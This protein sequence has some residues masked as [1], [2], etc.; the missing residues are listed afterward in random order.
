MNSPNVPVQGVSVAEPGPRAGQA[1][2]DWP[3]RRPGR[4]GG[5]AVAAALSHCLVCLHMPAVPS[6]GQVLKQITYLVFRGIVNCGAFKMIFHMA[7][8]F[9]DQEIPNDESKIILRWPLYTVDANGNEWLLV[10]ILMDPDNLWTVEPR[11][12]YSQ[13]GKHTQKTE[14]VIW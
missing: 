4:W 1:G 2:L 9:L 12:I 14:N 13:R 5:A 3:L 8:C 6:S 11:L 10:P 7:E